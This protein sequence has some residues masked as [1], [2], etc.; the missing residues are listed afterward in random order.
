[1]TDIVKLIAYEEGWRSKPYLCSEHYPTVGYGFKLST[2]K[3]HLEYF[4]FSLPRA[5]GDAWLIELLESN[6]TQMQEHDGFK[7][8]LSG[9]NDARV[10]VLM[11]MVYQIGFRGVSKFKRMLTAMAEQNWERAADEML[12][13]RW[14]RQTANRAKRHAE[15][16]RSGLW[17]Q[18]YV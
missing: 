12:D 15:Q 6:M 17:F 8:A 7:S 3:G 4:N 14:A 9:C 13:S 16:M 2:Q 10:A 5:A 18:G 11:S 1:M